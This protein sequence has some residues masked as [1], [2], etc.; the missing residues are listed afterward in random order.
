MQTDVKPVEFAVLHC[1]VAAVPIKSEVT[2]TM[3]QPLLISGMSFMD[4]K[5]YGKMAFQAFCYYI[6]TTVSAIFTGIV[7]VV[8]IQPGKNKW[9]TSVPSAGHVEPVQ[10]VDAFLDLIRCVSNFLYTN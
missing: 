10:T 6:G 4:R 2:F 1:T 8:L 7:L 9:R 5:V 3:L